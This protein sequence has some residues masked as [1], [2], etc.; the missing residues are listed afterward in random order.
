MWGP[1]GGRFAADIY[2]PG[3]Q[4]PSDNIG[5]SPAPA[6]P[7]IAAPTAMP[8]LGRLTAR[9]T[10]PASGRGL[11]VARIT[12]SYSGTTPQPAAY[13][14]VGTPTRPNLVSGTRTGTLDECEYVRALYVPAG[15]DLCVVW[16]APTGDASARIEY[17]EA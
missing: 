9:L 6:L 16:E 7:S 10:A 14:Y 3:G 15:Q 17:Q 13:V 8:E 5:L 4:A 12:V 2:N 1:Q 11:M